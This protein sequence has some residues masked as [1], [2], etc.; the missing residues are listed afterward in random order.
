MLTTG[1]PDTQHEWHETY[2]DTMQNMYRTSYKDM[3]HGRE[4]AVKNDMPAG[5][6][7]HVLSTRHD[8]LF[9]N[10]AFDRKSDMLRTDPARD[11]MPSFR[12][13]NDGVPSSTHFPRGRKKPPTAGTVP[14]ALVKPPWALTSS[15]RVPPTFRTSPPGSARS[16][17]TPR[18]V[19]SSSWA[20]M[21]GGQRTN[22]AAMT[23]GQS[24]SQAAA[25]VDIDVPPQS[26]RENR[27][28]HFAV[29]SA[30]EEAARHRMP[31]EEEI[32]CQS[33]GMPM[34]NLSMRN[35][36]GADSVRAAML[37]PYTHF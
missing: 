22:T 33:A 13:Q 7:G 3:I 37:R 11:V 8:V 1:N 16:Q 15:I 27:G 21:S 9:R 6:G 17:T 5:Y 36:E 23:A 19:S 25:A 32:L 18:G 34:E 2:R 31:T 10:T 14:D 29:A 20:G 24:M 35:R 26:A 30:N 28:L 4:V 12:E